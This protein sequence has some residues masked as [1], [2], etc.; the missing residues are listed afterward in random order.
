MSH[1]IYP[2][3]AKVDGFDRDLNYTGIITDGWNDPVNLVPVI[4]LVVCL[5]CGLP[6]GFL[7]WWALFNA[8]IIHPMDLYVISPAPTAF[9]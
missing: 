4:L 2:N 6:N 7:S 3:L 8:A 5:W 1:L 9:A